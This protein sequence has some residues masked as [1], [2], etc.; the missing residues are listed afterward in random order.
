MWWREVFSV[1]Y[2]LAWGGSKA[3][4]IHIYKPVPYSNSNLFFWVNHIVYK[5]DWN[6]DYFI[7]TLSDIIYLTVPIGMENSS[8]NVDRRIVLFVE[9]PFPSLSVHW[10][11]LA[12][13][14]YYRNKKQQVADKSSETWTFCHACVIPNT[15]VRESSLPFF[16]FINVNI[17]IYDY[18]QKLMA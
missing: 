16:L 13:L 9:T 3:R 7:L 5:F 17:F 12:L 6:L 8:L 4:Y 10:N 1:T 15:L 14:N 11:I 2:G 18:W